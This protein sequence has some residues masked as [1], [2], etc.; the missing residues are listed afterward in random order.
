MN[1][2][3]AILAL[4]AGCKVQGADWWCTD[5]VLTYD[6]DDKKAFILRGPDGF[7]KTY[8]FYMDPPDQK[9]KVVD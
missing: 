5:L 1:R 3:Q 2:E 7:R 4:L 8:H 6:P 9:W